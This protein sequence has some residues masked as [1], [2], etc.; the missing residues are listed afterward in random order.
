MPS[1]PG[2]GE[3]CSESE[4]QQTHLV[5]PPLCSEDRDKAAV[6]KQG[7]INAGGTKL[8]EVK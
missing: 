6:E 4:H 2:L 8:S 1:W 7:E 3:L 5:L